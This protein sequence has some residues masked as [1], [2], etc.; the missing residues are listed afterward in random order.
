MI[1]IYDIDGTLT[2]SGD[3]PRTDLIEHVKT[4]VAEDQARI[5]IVSGRPISRLAETEEWLKTNGVP[6][7]RIFLNDFNE[8]PG[9]NVVEAFK[10]WKYA[11]IVDE[12]G[13]GEIDYVV[14]ESAEARSNAEGMGIDAYS[15]TEVLEDEAEERSIDLLA[16]MRRSA[17]LGLKF[18]AEGK[19]GDGLTD[20]TIEEARGIAEGRI[21]ED[22]VAR[23]GAWIA[24]HRADW[25]GVPQNSDPTDDRFP[26]PGAVAAYLWA[27]DPTDAEDTDRVLAWVERYIASEETEDED[28]D[29]ENREETPTMTQKPAH[30]PVG[31][32]YRTTKT[33]A[34]TVREDG[35]TF[36]GYVALFDSPSEGLGFTEVI[37]PTAFNRTLSRAERGEANIV[38]LYGHDPMEFLGSTAAGNLTLRTDKTGLIAEL[39]LPSTQRGNDL[40]ALFD[41]GEAVSMGMSF[42]FSIPTKNG[43]NWSEDGAVRELREIRLHEVSLLSG[44]QT[45]AYPATIGLGSVRA[46]AARLD[47]S[48]EEAR[49]AVDALLSG[50]VTRT[51]ILVRALGADNEEEPVVAPVA[52]EPA[53]TAIIEEE[54]LTPVVPP[55]TLAYLASIEA[56][57]K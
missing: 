33:S 12:F 27:I 19:G 1:Q 40:A 11:K 44:G 50:D 37:K 56:R 15:P 22:K 2:T 47:V 25:E 34:L 49:D 43:E 20:Q 51:A 31:M 38:A 46:L 48:P 5:F 54:A 55:S 45:P 13:L 41:A 6:Y 30:L 16:K 57:R 28:E 23:M 39:A 32:E 36:S 52:D 29:E 4:E 18:Y 8:N 17:E 10:A 42:G 24:R 3:T 14:D 9:P 7:E 35:R 53:L 26:G 21:T